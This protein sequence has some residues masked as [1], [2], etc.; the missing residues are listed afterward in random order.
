MTGKWIALFF[1]LTSIAAFSQSDSTSTNDSLVIVGDIT[2]SGNKIT[3]DKIIAREL[4]LQEGDTLP[5]AEFNKKI[6]KSHDNLMNRSLFNFVTFSTIPQGNRRNV[7]IDFIERWYI[8]PIPILDFADRNINAWWETKDF[9]RIDYGIDLRVENFRGRMETLH[10]IV[11]GGYNK[12]LIARWEIPYIDKKQKFGM[13]YS[14][15]AVF[16]RETDYTIDNN[17]PVYYGFE[18]DYAKKYYFA[19]VGVSYRFGFNSFHNI[20]LSYN[21]LWYND[22]LLVLNP[23]LTYGENHYSYLSLF[24]KYKLDYRD[25]K[26]Y[27]LNGHYFDIQINKLGLGILGSNMDYASIEFNFD[28]Y[29]KLYKRFYFAYRLA[30][31]FSNKNKFQPYLIKTGMELGDFDMRGYELVIIRGQHIGLLKSNLKFEVIPMK[32]HRIKWIKTEKFGKLFYAL[33]ANLFFDAGY[34]SDY[35]TAQNNP[36]ANQYLWSTG[37]GLD[38]ISFY[39]IVIRLEYSINKQKQTGFYVGLVAPI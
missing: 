9:S 31:S 19:D 38:L 36:L 29:F 32:V 34:V 23:N 15:G 11:Q 3:K 30:A 14:A 1:L 28:H 16:N 18:N 12:A 20:L 24:Y 10:V 8:W 35:Q 26:P 21:N 22:S 33:Y 2:W 4:E 39:D 5:V 37:I 13:S 27:P 17:R 7:H 6:S 25:Y